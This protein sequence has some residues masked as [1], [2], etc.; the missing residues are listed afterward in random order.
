MQDYEDVIFGANFASV[1][2]DVYEWYVP[3]KAQLD[4]IAERV[5]DGSVL[6]VGAGTGRVAIPLAER[7]VPVV[8]LDVSPEMLDILAAK[9][10]GLPIRPMLADGADFTL[11]EK[12]SHVVAVFNMVT[13]FNGR[14]EQRKFFRSSAAALEPGGELIVETMVPKPEVLPGTSALKVRSMSAAQVILEVGN[15]VPSAQRCEFQYIL[16]RHEEPVRLL[17]HRM[18]YLWPDQLD[19]LAAEAGLELTDRYG[20]WRKN[21]FSESSNSHVSIYRLKA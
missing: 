2:D 5:G 14:E 6:E 7:G 19:G 17:P 8:A 4:L 11:E 16:F 13:L 18:H 9:A 1:Y 12:V 21:P 3:S 10:E 20:G 15:H